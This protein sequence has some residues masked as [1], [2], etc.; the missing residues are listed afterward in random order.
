MTGGGTPIKRV[1]WY[2]LIAP[3]AAGL[4]VPLLVLIALMLIWARQGRIA[5]AVTQLQ[6]W[7]GS[8]TGLNLLLDFSNLLIL[9]F[10][11]WIVSRVT[12]PALPARFRPL[13][14]RGALVGVAAGL[15]GVA[16]SA[17]VEYLSDHYLHTDLGRDGLATMVL[18]HRADQLAL[19]LFTVAILAPLT[20]EIYFRG[21]VLGWLR[22]H[23]GL[24]WA[25]GLSSLLFGFMHLKWLT[26]GG[27]GGMVATAELVAMGIL[28]ALVAARTG[29]LWA[30]FI[31][32]GV[33][34]LCAALVA[35]FWAHN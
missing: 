25:I 33:N 8:F 30:S 22:R 29:S 7:L 10:A 27:T 18:P 24:N 1:R 12:D 2:D 34:N 6:A 3:Q 11:L 5:G 19:G 28:L 15:G 31:T 35:V 4:G 20:E 16:V 9:G 14:R 23:W 13:S 26:P 17:T 21:L 32:H